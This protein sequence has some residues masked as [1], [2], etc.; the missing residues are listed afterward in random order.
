VRHRLAVL[1][2]LAVLA[3]LVVTTVPAGAVSAA[4]PAAPTYVSAPVP[5]DRG[6]WV[7]RPEPAAGLVEFARRHGVGRL[8]VATSSEVGRG[9]RRRLATTVRLA[10]RHG[11]DVDALGG[12]PVWVL[13]QRQALEWA[14][15]A[16]RVVG[17]L[18]VDAE[19]HGLPAWDTRRRHVVRRYLR[20]LER[21]DALP[22]RLEV[23]VAFWYG[24]IPAPG[25]TLADA[26]LARVDAVTVMSYRDEALGRNGILDVSR[27]WLRRGR[28]AGVPVTLGAETNPL[29]D[30]PHC[31]FA[32]EGAAALDREQ[33]V[34]ARRLRGTSA[35]AGLAVHDRAGWSN[36][37]R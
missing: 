6:L 34:V 33:R 28:A 37:V 16:V 18:H 15:E 19:P 30:C 8:W 36:L 7:W 35:F 23:D 13:R 21:L 9:E 27:D 26:V 11:I 25:G 22:G 10:R 4:A 1:A 17:D 20:L 2:V 14:R 32:E 31:T 3:A 5:A 29:A 12:A 24:D